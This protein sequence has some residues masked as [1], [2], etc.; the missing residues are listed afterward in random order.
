MNFVIF[1]YN[2]LPQADAEAYCTTR[3]ASALAETGHSV[4]VVTMDHPAK[5][6]QEVCDLLV[7]SKLK[8]TRVPMIERARGVWLRLKYMTTEWETVNYRM[9]IRTLREVLKQYD[10]PILISR[11]L[12]ESSHI[13]AYHARRYA[14]KWIAHFSDPI[15]FGSRGDSLKCRLWDGLSLRWMRKTIKACD[16]VSVTCAEAI[17]FYRETYRELQ[18][19]KPIF[20]TQHIGDPVL[21]VK[22]D[23]ENPISGK[24]LVHMGMMAPERGAEDILSALDVINE[25]GIKL[26]FVQVGKTSDDVKEVFQKRDDVLVFSDPDPA[27]GAAVA[28]K[29][30]ISFIPDVQINL[31]YTPFLPSKFVYQIFGGKPLVLYTRKGSSMYRIAKTHPNAGLVLA[32]YTQKETLVAALANVVNADTKGFDRRA[33]EHEFSQTGVV[34]AFIK[35]VNESLCA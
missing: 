25:K 13:I 7:S 23:W 14:W 30:D 24:M 19:K 12:P 33:L 4:H 15:P 27:L 35:G 5:V 9:A 22:R 28:A 26:W 21:P 31:P 20:V 18:S 32:D 6:S 11:S 29:A 3:F 8:I 1:S 10:K 34:E 17:R 2:F 16:G